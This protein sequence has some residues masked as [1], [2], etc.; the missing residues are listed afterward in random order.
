[1]NLKISLELAAAAYEKRA[2]AKPNG[3][4]EVFGERVTYGTAAAELRRVVA[5]VYPEMNTKDIQQIVRCKDC[6]YCRRYRSK[7]NPKAPVKR[8]CS[9]D[10]QERRPDF[11]CANGDSKED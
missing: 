1:M 7:K 10:G 3:V 4:I 5:F 8:V 11:F 2:N 6:R 9:I